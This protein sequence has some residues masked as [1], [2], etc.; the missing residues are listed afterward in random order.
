MLEGDWSDDADDAMNGHRIEITTGG[1]SWQVR[2]D[3]EA[4][5][6]SEGDEAADASVTGEP[7][8]VLLWLWGGEPDERVTRSGELDLHRL[9]RTRLVLATQ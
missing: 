7:S 2:L 1:R 6:V 3:R 9:M 8:D 5:T 4:V